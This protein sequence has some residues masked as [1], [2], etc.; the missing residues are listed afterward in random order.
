MKIV[1]ELRQ[2]SKDELQS[3][4]LELRKEQFTLRMK[5]SSG[6]LEKTHL[7][8]IVR[9]SIAKVKTLLTEKVGT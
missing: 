3:K 2:L 6:A 8:R 7:V 5:K 1:E 4:L 9:K